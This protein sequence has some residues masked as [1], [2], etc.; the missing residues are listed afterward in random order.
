M[1]L[2]YKKNKDLISRF[3]P[4]TLISTSL[5][6]IPIAYGGTYQTMCSYETIMEMQESLNANGPAGNRGA[7]KSTKIKRNTN[8]CYVPVEVTAEAI[9]SPD[10]TIPTSRVTSWVKTGYSHRRINTGVTT[11]IL[12]GPLGA[13][14]FLSKKH[15]Y[16]FI[17]KGFDKDG[18]KAS[19]QMDFFKKL[20]VERLSQELP[21]VTGLAMGEKRSFLDVMKIRLGIL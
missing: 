10:V 1:G 6:N 2:N 3:V 18:K 14:G 13:L 7:K 15:Q 8:K 4:I 5:I 9:V 20:S 19:I 21:L 11:T 12:F 16:S 17:I